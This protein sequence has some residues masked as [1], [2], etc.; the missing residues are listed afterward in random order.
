MPNLPDKLPQIMFFAEEHAYVRTSDMTKHVSMSSVQR[1]YTPDFEGEY[2]RKNKALREVVGEDRWRAGKEPFGLKFPHNALPPG[3]LS[4]RVLDSIAATLSSEERVAANNSFMRLKREWELKQLIFSRLGTKYHDA[5]ENRD[6][7]RGGAYN[8]VTGHWQDIPLYV[9][10]T[11]CDNHSLVDD[12]ADLPDGYYPELLVWDWKLMLMGQLDRC[13]IWTVKNVT[14]AG[15]YYPQI[16]YVAPLD[17]KTNWAKG[18]Y[19]GKDQ[20]TPFTGELLPPFHGIPDTKSA[21]YGIQQGGYTMILERAGFTPYGLIGLTWVED[22]G[23]G[24]IMTEYIPYYRDQLLEVFAQRE[25][26]VAAGNLTMFE[27]VS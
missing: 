2:W 16:R 8:P 5:C 12:L 24:R 25:K 10:K 26:E 23:E 1:K 20:I 21:G 22:F 4:E 14:I 9:D 19:A 13:W 7:A 27:D 6:I 3:E 17:Y 11:F 15:V 18:P